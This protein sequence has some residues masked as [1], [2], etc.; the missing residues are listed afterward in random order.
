[1]KTLHKILMLAIVGLYLPTI[2]ASAQLDELTNQNWTDMSKKTESRL[3]NKAL[4][5]VKEYGPGYYRPEAKFDIVENEFS[6][7]GK[8][9]NVL[10]NN[11]RMYY[12]VSFLYDIHEE[13]FKSAFLASVRFWKDTEEPWSITFGNGQ[14]VNF[15]MHPYKKGEKAHKIVPF[16]QDTLRMNLM[17]KSMEEKER[18]KFAK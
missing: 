3:V 16:E 2:H 1:M 6:Q 17:K 14:Q 10:Q 7:D 12:I 15:L 11:G 9:E 18:K 13:I 4:E 5:L 8:Y